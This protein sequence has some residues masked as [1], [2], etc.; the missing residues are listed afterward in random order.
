MGGRP[1]LAAAEKANVEL[2]VLQAMERILHKHTKISRLQ[3]LTYATHLGYWRSL[4][5][6]QW[7]R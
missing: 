6:A 7:I 1:V 2:L 5:M 4:L 3:S